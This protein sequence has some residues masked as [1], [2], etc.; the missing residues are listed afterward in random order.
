MEIHLESMYQEAARSQGQ[1]LARNM[2][3]AS[4]NTLLALKC[5]SL[6]EEIKKM[7]SGENSTVVP[8]KP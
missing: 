7:K 3:L 6:E 1:L 4:L 5:K 2:E 8:I